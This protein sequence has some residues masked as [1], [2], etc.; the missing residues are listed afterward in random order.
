MK[1]SLRDDSVES[2]KLIAQVFLMWVLFFAILG[3]SLNIRFLWLFLT[4]TGFF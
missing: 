3:L 2:I 1:F 4:H